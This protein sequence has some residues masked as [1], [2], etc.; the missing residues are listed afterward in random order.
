MSHETEWKKSTETSR[1]ATRFELIDRRQRWG[2][3]RV[4][5]VTENGCQSYM[6]ASWTDTGP[7]L[8]GQTM[9]VDQASELNF[10]ALAPSDPAGTVSTFLKVVYN[11]SITRLP[12][13]QIYFQGQRMEEILFWLVTHAAERDGQ[14]RIAYDDFGAKQAITVIGFDPQ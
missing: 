8:N 14:L 12:E 10:Y 5:Y 4:Y 3:W 6:P 2:Q 11:G 9:S 7:T 13:K 1:N